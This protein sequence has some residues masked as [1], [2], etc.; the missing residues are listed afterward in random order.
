MEL[1]NVC[2]LGS[3]VNFL[4]D[5]G[6]VGVNR[7]FLNGR[8]YGILPDLVLAYLFFGVHRVVIR[9]LNHL[10]NVVGVG[11]IILSQ[12]FGLTVKVN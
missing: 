10:R 6:N 2:V 3:Y 1:C 8:G 7:L 11:K 9:L 5:C 4:F 12:L